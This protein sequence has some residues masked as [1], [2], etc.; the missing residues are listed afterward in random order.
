ME[1]AKWDPDRESRTI[2]HGND[3]A[4]FADWQK[5]G[6]SRG[7]VAERVS[8]LRETADLRSKNPET[9][10]TYQEAEANNGS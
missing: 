5:H 10:Q 6:G 3:E 2:E 4:E 8:G 1:R 9:Q 7:R